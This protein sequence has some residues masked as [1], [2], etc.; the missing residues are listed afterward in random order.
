MSRISARNWRARGR[1]ERALRPA[2]IARK[3]SH[4]SKNQCGAEAFA[5]FTS[6]ARTVIMK[7][8][9]GKIAHEH[10]WWDQASLLV[11]VGLLSSQSR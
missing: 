2:V 5:A 7:F 6:V 4:C 10:V 9:N 1:A 8:E 3:V 11:P